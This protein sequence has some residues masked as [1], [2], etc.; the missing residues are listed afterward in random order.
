MVEFAAGFD[1]KL[2]TEEGYFFGLEAV[3]IFI[4]FVLLNIIHPGRVLVGPP[5][6]FGK[7]TRQEKRE[8][9]ERKKREKL[10]Q[11]GNGEEV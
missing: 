11:Y 6:D 9:K 3:P 7:L 1:S 2:A 8:K 4:A 10:G 5:S